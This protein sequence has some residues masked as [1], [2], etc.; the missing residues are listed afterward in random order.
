MNK[1]DIMLVVHDCKELYFKRTSREYV[2]QFILVN[3]PSLVFAGFAKCHEDDIDFISD[4]TGYDLARDRATISYLNYKIK[5]AQ[6]RREEVSNAYSSTHV[7][8]FK[9]RK[10][11]LKKEIEFYHKAIKFYEAKIRDRIIS[12]EKTN[13]WIRD[14]DKLLNKRPL[15]EK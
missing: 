3:N 13:N 9:K 10:E 15:G 11:T 14:R 8:S 4:I 6:S 7:K 1:V 2:Y 5:D 12:K